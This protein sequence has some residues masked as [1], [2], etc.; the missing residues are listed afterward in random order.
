TIGWPALRAAER[1]AG[2]ASDLPPTKRACLPAA[3]TDATKALALSRASCVFSRSKIS[4][5]FFIPKTYFLV[6]GCRRALA[7]PKW[8]P[9]LNIACT[10]ESLFFAVDIDCFAL[11]G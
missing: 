2:I 8:P 7:R 3:A 6:E 9:A 4:I 10:T 1:T 5:S 11:F